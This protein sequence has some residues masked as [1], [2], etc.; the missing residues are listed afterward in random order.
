ML[1][2]SERT[3]YRLVRHGQLVGVHVAAGG[4]CL[5]FRG[6]DVRRFITSRLTVQGEE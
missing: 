3:V 1:Q 4:R 5:R 2:T 6:E